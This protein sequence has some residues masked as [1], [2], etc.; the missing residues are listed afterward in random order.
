MLFRPIVVLPAELIVEWMLFSVPVLIE[1][2]VVLRFTAIAA[3]SSLFDCWWWRLLLE[4][5]EEEEWIIDGMQ[6]VAVGVGGG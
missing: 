5:K 3:I 4:V 1:P 2:T 6:P